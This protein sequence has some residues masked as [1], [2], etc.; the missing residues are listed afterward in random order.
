MVW[1]REIPWSIAVML[2]K[3]LVICW[4]GLHIQ[5]N[6]PLS[7]HHIEWFLSRQ[8]EW[9]RPLK[10]YLSNYVHSVYY[11]VLCYGLVYISFTHV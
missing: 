8:L 5:E 3:A 6:N 7:T 11:I 10:L 2:S 9:I 4:Q 1:G